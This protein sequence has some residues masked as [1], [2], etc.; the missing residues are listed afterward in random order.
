MFRY[1]QTSYRGVA[2]NKVIPQLPPDSQALEGRMPI[3]HPYILI[4]IDRKVG[5]PRFLQN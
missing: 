3:Y 2:V 4:A 5:F 1:H